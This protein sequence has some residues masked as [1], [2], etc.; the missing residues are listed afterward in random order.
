MDTTSATD[1]G[2]V[3]VAATGGLAAGGGG[4]TGAATGGNVVSGL[5]TT[6]P[7][8]HLDTHA[9]PLLPPHTLKV[10]FRP[11][12]SALTIGAPEVTHHTSNQFTTP[13][14]TPSHSTT[15]YHNL[16]HNVR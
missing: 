7:P 3:G 16:S 8:L 10:Q 12:P 15:S 14:H 9:L 13:Y 5:S 4:G 11:A 6:S 1:D 2:A